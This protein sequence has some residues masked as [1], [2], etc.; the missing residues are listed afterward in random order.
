M[1]DVDSH[2]ELLVTIPSVN[3]NKIDTCINVPK[4]ESITETKV[5]CF[6]KYFRNF[7]HNRFL[8]SFSKTKWN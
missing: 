2:E 5:V 3:R 4:K 8:L 1:M 7:S 6:L